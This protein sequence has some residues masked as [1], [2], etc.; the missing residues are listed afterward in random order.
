[1]IT[2]PGLV[3]PHVHLRDP[4][5]TQKE[6]AASGTAAALAGGFTQI[7]VMPNTAPPVGDLA[8]FE[9]AQRAIAAN[10]R[11][12]VGLYAAGLNDNLSKVAPL[13][14][15]TFGLKLWL[16]SSF[17][18]FLLT[19]ARLVESHLLNWPESSPLLVHAEGG[20]RFSLGYMLGLAA[21]HQRPVHIL[22]VAKRDEILLIRAAK[23]KGLPVT[24]ET[25]PQYLLLSQ[26]DLPNLDPILV[27][28]RPTIGTR[29]DRQALWDNLEFIDCIGSD[30]APHTLAEKF[31]PNAM[32]GMPGL[33]TSLAIMLDSV[34][35]GKLD[36]DDIILRMATN[37]RKIFHLPEQADTYIEIDPDEE[38]TVKNEQLFTKVQWSP[39]AGYRFKGRVKRVVLRGQTAYQ[40]GEI[41]AEPGSGKII[42]PA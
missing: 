27:D 8:G 11:C 37:P 24:C 28:A 40:S 13:S 36:L 33:E 4:G 15:H 38:W 18:N 20:G 19:D 5:Q 31:S 10:I 17:G 26:E 35:Q 3:D 2:L 30:H 1:M 34:H 42:T 7:L 9:T 32:P 6:D 12:D 16:D 39:F 29:Q 22:H 14:A 23:E 41:L 21:I 25:C